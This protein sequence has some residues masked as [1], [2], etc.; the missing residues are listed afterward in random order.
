[1]SAE[2]ASADDAIAD[3]GQRHRALDW[4]ASF[5]V[6]APAGSGKTEL[7]IQRLLVLLAQVDA[8][9]EV[10]ALTFTRKA[11]GEMRERVLEALDAAL[12]HE[13][14][15]ASHARTTWELARAVQRR[16]A[17]AGWGLRA[18]PNRLRVMTIDA[19]CAGL[20]RQR[21]ILS[22]FGA[23]PATVEDAQPLYQEAARRTLAMLDDGDAVA[24][25]LAR[26]LRH[27]DNDARAVQ[28][29]LA[30]MLR[31]RDQWLRH[32]ADRASPRLE[33]AALEAALERAIDDALA[34]LCARVPGELCQELVALAR[35]AAGNLRAA[36]ADSPIVLLAD[37]EALPG[38]GSA[39]LPLWRALAELLLTREGSVRR[40]VDANCGFLAP[41]AARGEDAR[42][43]AHW[44]ARAEDL[45][46]RL[47]ADTGLREALHAARSLPPGRYDEA[48]WET[49]SALTALLPVAV[50]QLNLLFAERGQVDFTA[51]AQ[52]AAA[53]LGSDEAPTDLALALDHRICHVLVDEFQDTSLA[54]YELLRRLAAGWQDGDGRT[55][56]LVGDPMQSIYRFREA[57]VALFLQARR[58]GVGSVRLEPLTLTV[59]FRSQRAVVDWV[60]DSFAAL[61]PSAED[62][63]SGAVAYSA[64]HAHH[65]PLPGEA[66]RVHAL[67]ATDR[68]A[69]ARVVADL[70][71]EA[72]AAD[73]GQRIAILV[74]GRSHLAHVVPQLQAY[75]LV[76]QTIEIEALAHRPLVQDLHT[77]ARA[78]LHPA[79]RAAWLALLRAPWCGLTLPDLEALAGR[80]QRA[81]VWSLLDSAAARAALPADARARATRV[82]AVLAPAL[83]QRRRGSLRRWI[84]GA[85]LALGGPA[86]ARDSADLEDAQVFLALLEELEQG[87][88]IDDFAELERRMQALHALPDAR[89]DARLQA[90]TIHKAKGLEFDVVIVPGLGYR[91]RSDAP[92][93]LAWQER[94]R[95][96]HES[97]L[98][99]AP[100]RSRGADDDP[101]H[102]WLAAL[103]RAK[104]RHEDTRL[105]YVA[106]TR[107]KSRLH[108]VGHAPLD[109]DGLPQPASGS[110]LEILWPVLEPAY[111]AQAARMPPKPAT[112]AP[113]ASLPQTVLRRLAHD[114]SM[115]GAEVRDIVL[116][117][118]AAPD[119]APAPIEFSWASQTAR[120]AGTLVHATLQAIAQDGLAAWSA[121]AVRGR[122]AWFARDLRALGV[123]EPNLEAALKRVQRALERAL[124]DPRA[125]WIL[126]PHQ[127]AECEPR[128][129]AR[130]DGALVDVA[131]DR[132]FVD[133][134]GVRWIVDYKTS[135]HE[136]GEL[137]LFLDREQARYRDQLERY[138]RIVHALDGRP[139][140]VGLYFP[141]LGAWREWQP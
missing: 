3:A 80:D 105:L 53:A 88:D 87:G 18:S 89:A 16:D 7:L 82:H 37:C 131:L 100:I 104:V 90:M 1:M 70:V 125:R 133:E 13:P 42:T 109:R 52:G 115:P 78:L 29:L 50:A 130:I 96:G 94:A 63:A 56:F 113:A 66:V 31:R 69:E 91:T 5:I 20:A 127:Q 38:S 39:Q 73:P 58:F 33:R 74:R 61:M 132:T 12:G 47:G 49:V 138:A 128:L 59:N 101:I 77:L 103:E 41:S 79:D 26:L 114:W 40:R 86:A 99:L 107:A 35:H 62:A 137:D 81:C 126:S 14:P 112:P 102:A 48:Q 98:L 84:E 9:D 32:V 34:Q 21:P 8:P 75:G 120:H 4:R 135:T 22:A 36:A 76:P 83:A 25:A 122:R 67:L 92:Q 123:P 124:A 139:V 28:A 64:S 111:R 10:I 68:A 17:E 15:A 118:P 71:R 24:A 136:G 51:V 97:D 129:S 121:E 117:A 106:A 43:R 116:A 57:E 54:Q 27:L 108:W 45:L 11:A 65:L 93:L 46:Q 60:N 110:L 30:H 19:L 23:A 141:L 44:K 95:P 85:W 72:R 2:T 55:L 6:Q 119:L 134:C 140:R